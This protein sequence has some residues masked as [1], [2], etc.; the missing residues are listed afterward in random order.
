MLYK[1]FF[2]EI[3]YIPEG[4]HYIFHHKNFQMYKKYSVQGQYQSQA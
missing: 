3:N 4:E 1:L 2:S